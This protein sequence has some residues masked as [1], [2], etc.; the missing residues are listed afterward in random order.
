[1]GNSGNW[2]LSFE[3]N[4]TPC[5][6]VEFGLSNV[7]RNVAILDHVSDLFAHSGRE[8]RN[9]I[10]QENGPEDRNVQERNEGAENCDQECF[11]SGQPR[12]ANPSD[13]VV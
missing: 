12:S 5:L 4:I 6:F 11:D 2:L 7:E 1:M 13:H 3:N 8:K 10:N 9:K